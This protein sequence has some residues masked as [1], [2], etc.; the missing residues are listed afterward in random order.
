VE[1]RITELMGYEDEIVINFAISSLEEYQ[2]HPDKR[3]DPK[4]L[5][6]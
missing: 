2:G 6:V 1:R 4:H 5:Q 3:L